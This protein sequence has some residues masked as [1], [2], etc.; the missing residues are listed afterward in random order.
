MFFS[1]FQ[2]SMTTIATTPLHVW[3]DAARPRTLGAAVAPVL[4]GTALAYGDGAL[5]LPSALVALVCALLIQIGTN[6]GNDYF[7]FVKGTDTSDRLGPTRATSAGLVK[8]H[9]MLQATMLVFGLACIGGLYLIW[10]GGWPILLIGVLSILSGILYTAGRHAFGYLGL[11]DL[12]VLI[13]FG[14]VAVA[15]TYY[16]QALDVT[17]TSI[18]AG[19]G[20][21]LL[22]VA[23]L[24]VNNLRDVRSD[25]IAGKRTLAVRF[26]EQFARWEYIAC[27]AGAALVALVLPLFGAPFLVVLAALVLVLARG[28]IFAVFVQTG[29]ALNPIL[30]ATNRL[31]L[32]YS[33][34][35]S[36]GLML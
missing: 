16:V 17:A 27:V 36:L 14:P 12:F 13:F 20:P 18:I 31:L 8:P 5:H 1:I 24:V 29:R 10:R 25:R 22:S 6:Y 28:P 4:I 11:G 7:D 33:L 35:L 3:L 26:G 21:G 9:T 19:F 32:L 30:G 2:F 15:G 34:L 23:I